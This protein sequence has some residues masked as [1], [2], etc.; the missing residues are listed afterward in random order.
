LFN[1]G[2]ITQVAR[3][4]TMDVGR[5]SVTIGTGCHISAGM[6]IDEEHRVSGGNVV[7]FTARQWKEQDRCR[8]Q[9][10]IPH[11]QHIEKLF[12]DHM[13]VYPAKRQL[14]TLHETCGR[15]MI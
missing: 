5:Q 9:I 10:G 3:I 12:V 13:R 7:Y 11:I 4:V 6:A 1:D 8:R 14:G 15:A 2:E